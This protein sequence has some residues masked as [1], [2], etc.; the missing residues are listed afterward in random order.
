MTI[1]SSFTGTYKFSA[2]NGS[3]ASGATGNV[4]VNS[5]VT[6]TWNGTVGLT[7]QHNWV[8]K[9]FFQEIIHLHPDPSGY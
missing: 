9:L 6:N 4:F 7:E 8:I 1:S 2:S 3:C 5:A